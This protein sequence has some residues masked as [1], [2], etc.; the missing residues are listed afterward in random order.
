LITGFITEYGVVT[1]PYADSIP[2]LE[3]RPNLAALSTMV[4]DRAQ[5]HRALR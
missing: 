4:M 3:T 2:D 1:A 5:E